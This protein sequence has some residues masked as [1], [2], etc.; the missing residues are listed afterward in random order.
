MSSIPIRLYNFVKTDRL[1]SLI[2]YNCMT[3]LSWSDKICNHSFK[4]CRYVKTGCWPVLAIPRFSHY[5]SG[6]CHGPLGST[7]AMMMPS[8]WEAIE[9][10]RSTRP[11]EDCH[12]RGWWLG[13]L[14]KAERQRCQWRHGSR[15]QTSYNDWNRPRSPLNSR[16]TAWWRSL[17]AVK[18]LTS[19][20]PISS[21]ERRRPDDDRCARLNNKDR[22]HLTRRRH[23]VEEHNDDNIRVGKSNYVVKIDEKVIFFSLELLLHCW[24]LVPF[25]RVWRAWR[26]LHNLR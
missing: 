18:M 15:Q 19:S 14:L 7:H 11:S 26:L 21:F 17:Y 3:Y 1:F 4:D 2:Q 16:L 23:P 10:M 6:P 9:M 5:S 13:R 24:N 20:R 22:Q 25:R 8:W 12:C